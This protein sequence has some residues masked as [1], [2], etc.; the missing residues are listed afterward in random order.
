MSSLEAEW[1]NLA[2]VNYEVD[3]L[4]L[5][6]FVPK[7]TIL[8]LWNGKCYVSLVAFMFRNTKI[9]GFKIPF[10][11]DFEE[12]NLRFYVKYNDN[13]QLKRGVVF[14]KEIVPKVAISLIANTLYHEHY[15]TMPMLHSWNDLKEKKQISYSWKNKGEW[16]KFFLEATSA[17]KEIEPGSKEEFITE[18]YW[19]YTKVN[20]RTTFEY[21]VVHPKWKISNVLNHQISV[22][23]ESL[24]GKKFKHLNFQIPQ[25][26]MLAEGSEIKVESKRRI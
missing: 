21:E 20:D 23:F 6:T 25:S 5:D 24:Y 17:K 3:P 14:I 1:R 4:L 11:V 18:H 7:G 9:L 13:N 16:N 8:D 19:G 12:V 15:E 10:H 26:L 2:I 22:D